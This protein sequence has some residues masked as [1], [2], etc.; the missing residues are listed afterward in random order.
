VIDVSWEDAG[1]YAR[2]LAERTDKK[3]RLPTEAE[4][5]YAAR[6]STT[7][8]YWWGNEIMQNG[9]VWA[10]CDTCSSEWGGKQTSPVGSFDPNPWDLYDTAGNV[11]E[12]VQD[13]W[14]GSYDG[15]PTEGSKPWLEENGGDCGRRVIRGGAWSY[16]PVYL[17]SAARFRLNP[18]GR[19][20]FV[21]IRLAQD[22][23]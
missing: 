17:R 13:C 19:Y 21:G 5:E 11:W 22:L 16:S 8:G 1:A 9:K 14:H 18:D 23:N 12:W 10:N 20:D 7:T 6:A 3:Y 15:A 4:W 2:W